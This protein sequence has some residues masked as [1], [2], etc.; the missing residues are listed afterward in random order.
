ML[1][2]VVWVGL[3]AAAMAAEHK[4]TVTFGGLPVPGASVTA[5]VAGTAKSAVT[6]WNGAY[7]IADLPDGKVTVRVEMQLFATQTREVDGATPAVWELAMAPQGAPPAVVSAPPPPPQNLKKP[8]AAA[9]NT[10]SA[11]QKA[12]LAGKQPAQP[13]TPAAPAAPPDPELAQRAADGLVI[14]GSVNNA[15]TSPFAQF[16]AFGN[17]RRG[18]RSLYNGNLGLILNHAA[19][20]AR[21]YSV[22]GQDTPKPDYTRAQGLFAF[23]GPIKIPKWLPRNGPMFTVNYQWTRNTNAIT[24]SGLVPTMAER[25]GDFSG[26]AVAPRD[27]VTGLPFAGGVIPPSR[28]SPQARALLGL[29]PEPNFTSSSRY[30]FQ[31]PIVSGMN[32][33]DLQTRVNKQ[34]RKNFFSG[35]FNWQS[36]RTSNPNLF[37]FL[38]T[39]RQMGLNTG[40]N[41][42][43]TLRPGFF[44]NFGVQ[45]SR[46]ND[47][48]TP[49]FSGQRNISGEAGIQGNNQEAVNWGPPSLTFS[50]GLANLG[51]AQ[52]SFTRNQTMAYTADAFYNR[53]RHNVTFGVTHRRQQFNVLAQQDARGSFT[54]TG[55]AAGNDVAG[56]LLGVPD[57]S[58]IAFGNADKYLRATITESFVN[59]D[60]RVNPAL[61]LNYG[62]RWEYWSPVSEKYGRLVNLDAQA[63]PVIGG[64]LQPDRNNWAPRIGF[65]WRP[66]AAS[67][68]VVRGGYGIYYDTS[69]YQPIAMQMAQ[70]AP[71]SKSLRVSNTPETPLTLANGFPNVA[72]TTFATTFAVDPQF[73]V[74]YSQNWQL[75][76]QRDL[77]AGLQLTAAYNGGKGTRAQQPY[78]PNTFPAG[79][80]E[81]SGYTFLASNGNSIRH[82]GNVQLRR[83]LRSGLTAQASYTWAKSLDNA[84][85]AGR[86]QG[87]S[88]TAQNWLDLSAERGRSN[89]DQRHLF[90]GMVQYTTGMG[91][92]GGA[93]ATGWKA[94]VLREWTLGSQ[95]TA[96]SGL[97]L[98]PVFPAA[99]RGTGV[100][101]NLRPD[102]TGL[103]LYDAPPGFFLNPLAVAAPAPG[104]WGN[105]GRNSIEGPSQF[106][107]SASLGRTFRSSERISYDFRLDAANALNSVRYPGWNTI[108]G[109]A[110]FGLPVT[111]SPMRTMQATIRARF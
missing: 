2:F 61:T 1:R 17:N 101:G 96:G 34:K 70:Q 104:R 39:G 23:G 7:A 98:S 25:A 93:L 32:Q 6:D 68:L 102:Y 13:G 91:L 29:F 52:A 4:G 107:M 79:A 71:L 89:F 80:V 27:P 69:I 36:T 111:A 37:G 56:F 5:T 60:W 40:A 21:S 83:R 8:Q 85:L 15:A 11:F 109:N 110:Q 94:K 55:A 3:C 41:Y 97:P 49:F 63:K 103:S 9:T 72:S 65:S 24:Q 62:V 51:D 87:G 28:I 64:T 31:T 19:F 100:T 58:S 106:A 105:A 35:N 46:Q 26:A 86:A 53:M 92:R 74:G 12:E 48:L 44:A 22:T 59:D 99:V 38:D 30:N 95:V 82:A 77:P 66:L 43:R 54:F 57:T 20:D 50:S 75:S 108:A 10:K 88:W 33:D 42:R 76:L 14:N 67:S 81:P 18:A 45:Y 73:R 16:P 47:R 84:I 78:L 90:T